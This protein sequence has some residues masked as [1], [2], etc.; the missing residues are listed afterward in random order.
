MSIK[1]SMLDERNL[2]IFPLIYIIHTL[3]IPTLQWKLKWYLLSVIYCHSNAS[4]TTTKSQ[5]HT[6]VYYSHTWSDWLDDSAD[7]DQA[8]LYISE[9]YIVDYLKWSCLG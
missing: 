4:K 2:E 8:H 9:W 7:L 5:R 6:R 3:L 1:F